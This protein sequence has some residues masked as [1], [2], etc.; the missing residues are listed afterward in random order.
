MNISNLPYVMIKCLLLTII[1]EV[2]I[3]LVLEVKTKKDILTVVLVNILTNPVVV[4]VPVF[5]Y[6]KLGYNAEIV[7][8]ILLE[9]ITVFVEGYIY[10]KRLVYKKINVF[11]LSLILNFMSYN[12]GQII[13]LLQTG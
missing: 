10:Y 5:I 12:I 7:S 4:S 2:V 1:I 11:I 13:Y 6:I 9:I 8:L 3:A